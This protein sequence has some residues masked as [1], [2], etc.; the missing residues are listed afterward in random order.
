MSKGQQPAVTGAASPSRR[1]QRCALLVIAITATLIIFIS[2]FNL[3]MMARDLGPGYQAK[4]AQP[5][6][7]A[8]AEFNQAK[9]KYPA[10]TGEL[11]SFLPADVLAME[12]TDSQTNTS[13]NGFG[14]FGRAG[15]VTW[16]Y[17][18]APSGTGY[19]INRQIRDGNVSYSVH[20]TN[21]VWSW[22]PGDGSDNHKRFTLQP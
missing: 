13:L 12:G 21:A 18:P 19:E 4:S 17:E 22:K 2:G 16:Q 6:I 15:G 14:L 8:L 7:K 5:I 20:G 3:W 1:F 11:F 10:K 9:G